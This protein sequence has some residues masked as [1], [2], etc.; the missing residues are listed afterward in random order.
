MAEA[1]ALVAALLVDMLVDA[2]VIC[3][4]SSGAMDL[5]MGGLP[6]LEPE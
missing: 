1:G 6:D 4:T 2:F 3:F 5:D